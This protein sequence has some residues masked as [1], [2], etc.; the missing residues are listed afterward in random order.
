MFN[1]SRAV[2]LNALPSISSLLGTTGGRSVTEMINNQ[3]GNSSFFESAGNVFKKGKDLF[4]QNFVDPI[5]EMAS[6]LKDLTRTL[7][8]P[9][10]D[11]MIPLTSEKDFIDI[12]PCMYLPILLHEPVMDL[13]KQGRIFGFGYNYEF[14][15]NQEDVYGRLVDNGR[16]TDV[17]SAIDENGFAEFKYEYK[18]TDPDLSWDQLDIIEQTRN[19]V[20]ELILKTK[21]DPTDI[22]S[23][24]G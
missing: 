20:D 18:S 17:A 15:K 24:R 1:V 2:T 12:P 21:K 11:V 13:F 4:V 6:S 14:V 7:N 3:F 9:K 19:Y 23:D 10:E 16:I 5:R 8:I 22:L